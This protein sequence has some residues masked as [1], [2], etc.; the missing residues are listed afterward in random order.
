MNSLRAR[1]FVALAAVVTLAGL[2]SGL[3]IYWWAYGEAVELQDGLI[4]QVGSLLAD[5][6]VRPNSPLTKSSLADSVLSSRHGGNQR[7]RWG[8]RTRFRAI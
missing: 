7:W 8:G 3:A 5:Q 2:V 1:L 6:R 4:V